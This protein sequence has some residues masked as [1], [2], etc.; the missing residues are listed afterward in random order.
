MAKRTKPD[1]FAVPDPLDPTQMSY[2]YRPVRGR[3]AGQI[4]PWPPRRSRWGRLGV[5]DI[6]VDKA[7]DPAGWGAFVDAYFGK[8]RAARA[9]VEA[10][11]EA[12]PDTA[13]ARFAVFG[14]RCCFCSKVL[15]DERSKVYGV[16][17][18]CRQGVSAE[19]LG[20]LTDVV[21]RVHGEHLSAA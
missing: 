20:H 16:G 19:F 10:A 5:K 14:F 21:R 15:T 9:A 12:D 2:W 11:I 1:Y 6:P 17:P 4:L 3:Q 8:V 18:E 13:A 7:A